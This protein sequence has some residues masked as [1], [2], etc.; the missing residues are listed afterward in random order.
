MFPL[1]YSKRPANHDEIMGR[2]KSSHRWLQEHNNDFYVKQAQR[3][4]LR[5]RAAFKLQEIQDK[6][7][8]FKPGMTVVDLG[9]APGG[10][11]QLSARWVG[12]RGFVL[13][14]DI[15]DMDSLED[16]TFVQGDF[17]EQEVLDL[18][19]QTLDGRAVDLVISDMAPNLSG[20]KEVDQPK[21]MYL[22]ELA[23]D[24]CRQVL[25]PEGN[26]LVKVFQGE[27]FDQYLQEMRTNF[28]Q[29]ISRKPKASRPRSREVYLL[30]KGFKA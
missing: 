18:L 30:A 1:L 8:L 7:K 22:A 15:L 25:K 2:S 17:T 21:A 4:G 12:S 13:A 9:A 14:S 3:L 29:V 20:V 16:V 24:M 5:S 10:W 23:L 28:K 6:D 19:L 27:G 11:S 26:F